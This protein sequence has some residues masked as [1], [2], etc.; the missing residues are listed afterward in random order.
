MKVSDVTH[1]K[2]ETLE[3]NGPQSL[4]SFVTI[5]VT[6]RALRLVCAQKPGIRVL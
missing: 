5:R 1:G 2:G 6:V 3:F 4:R